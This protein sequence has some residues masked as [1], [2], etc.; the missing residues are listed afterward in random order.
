[1]NAV[2]SFPLPTPAVEP[3]L[4]QLRDVKT[5]VDSYTVVTQA[6]TVLSRQFSCR[7]RVA[8]DDEL[9]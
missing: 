8:C 6:E 3:I 4:T 9:C 2:I 1:M 5:D 7:V